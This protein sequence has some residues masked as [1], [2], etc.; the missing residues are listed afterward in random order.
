M[1]GN[2][3]MIDEHETFR[4]YGYYSY[5]WSDK[6]SKPIVA[7]CDDCC[8]YRVLRINMYRDLC[9]SCSRRGERNPIF[10]RRRPPRSQEWCDKIS[11]G[12]KGKKRNAEVRSDMSK[13]RKGEK[14]G[15]YTEDRCKRISAGKQ[16][17]PFSEW[18]EFVRDDEYC[19]AFNNEI[20]EHI[21]EKY[22]RLCYICN[23]NE[24]DNGRRLDVHHADL[25][26]QQG[27]DD[28]AWKLVPLCQ[29]CHSSVHAQPMQARIEY[30]L[31][32]EDS[33]VQ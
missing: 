23:K 7:R 4:F 24:E 8:Q 18:T 25:Q 11:K 30:L 33:N 13:A 14:R 6:S 29:S 5:N 32:N 15:K 31:D 10:G 19:H 28:T 12:N 3:T 9:M 27:C 17:I 21:R 1:H 2:D 22:N 20:K 16:G 26:K